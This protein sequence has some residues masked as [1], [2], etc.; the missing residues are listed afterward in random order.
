MPGKQTAG[1]SFA[2]EGTVL[3]PLR[4]ILGDTVSGTAAL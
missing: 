1:Y 2:G 4:A 3:Y